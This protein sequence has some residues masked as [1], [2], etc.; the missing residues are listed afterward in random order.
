MDQHGQIYH[1]SCTMRYHFLARWLQVLFL[2]L[3]L[4]IFQT[5]DLSDSKNTIIKEKSETDRS[6]WGGWEYRWTDFFKSAAEK[7]KAQDDNQVT[8]VIT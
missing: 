5:T 2:Q 6:H 8:S 7:E 3:L 4:L 1:D